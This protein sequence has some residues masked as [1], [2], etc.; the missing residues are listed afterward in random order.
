MTHAAQTKKAWNYEQS[1][2]RC[3][4][5]MHYRGPYLLLINSLPRRQHASCKKGLFNVQ[6]TGCCDRCQAHKTLEGR[7]P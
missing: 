6:P 1:A 3:T 5:C 7:E 2:P 4:T